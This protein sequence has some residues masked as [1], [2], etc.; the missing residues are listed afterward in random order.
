MI[1]NN[2]IGCGSGLSA[3]RGAKTV[4]N[5]ANTFVIPNTVDSIAL[6]NSL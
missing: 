3:I 4:M 1:V 2:A 6:G 5:L